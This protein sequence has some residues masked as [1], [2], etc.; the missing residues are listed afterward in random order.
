MNRVP[1]REMRVSLFDI[2]FCALGHYFDSCFR[3]LG[4]Y[5]VTATRNCATVPLK[6]CVLCGCFPVIS[7]KERLKKRYR[8]YVLLRKTTKQ[9]RGFFSSKKNFARAFA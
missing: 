7:T 9:A 5:C 6:S 3:A 4:H 2:S 1:R 8:N